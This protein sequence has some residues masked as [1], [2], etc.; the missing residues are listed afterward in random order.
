MLLTRFK[1]DEMILADW[2]VVIG[3]VLLAIDV[4]LLYRTW[5]EDR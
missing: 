3:I 2:Y 5:K 1:E 4:A